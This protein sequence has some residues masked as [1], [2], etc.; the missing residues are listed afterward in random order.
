[1]TKGTGRRNRSLFLR[2]MVSLS[3][4]DGLTGIC[5]GIFDHVE[6][7]SRRA[8]NSSH[9]ETS[10]SVLGSTSGIELEAKDGKTGL[11]KL[12]P[13]AKRRGGQSGDTL[14]EVSVRDG[15]AQ[16]RR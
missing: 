16:I 13:V 1:M 12:I 5:P 8:V 2:E 4:P 9:P 15:L 6:G 14:S 10:P 7:V 3:C 11:A